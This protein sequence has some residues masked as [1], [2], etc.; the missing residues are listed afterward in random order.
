MQAATLHLNNDQENDFTLGGFIL[1]MAS[2]TKFE[3]FYFY[4]NITYVFHYKECNIIFLIG[5]SKFN[6]N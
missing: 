3:E 4:Q 6:F 2:I 5:N 1:V